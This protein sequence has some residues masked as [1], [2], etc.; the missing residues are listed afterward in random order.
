[1]IDKK[2]KNEILNG[3]KDKDE[4][5]IISNILDKAIK[6]EKVDS[7]YVSNFLNLNELYNVSQILDYFNIKYSIFTPYMDIEKKNIAFIPSYLEDDKEKVFLEHISCI[8]ISLNSRVRL[9][10]K[11]YMGAIYSLGV[12][13]EFVGDIIVKEN[14]AYFFCMK[15]VEEYFMYNL[16][17]VGK[18]EV[19]LD[20]V[21]ILSD[22]IKSLS[23]NF[24]E[25]EY[26]VPSLRIDAILSGVY[27]LSRSETK[28]KIVKGDLFINDKNIFYPNTLVKKDDIISF[29]KCGKLRIGEV[30]RNTKSG[31]L[32]INIYKYN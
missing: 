26:I 4:K 20:R 7:V 6:F 17:S 5:I 29:K 25:K 3:I 24:I 12:K 13:R 21:D 8:K 23:L 15:S 32:V 10:H 27:N 14:I 28:D 22:E 18:Y 11:D 16:N 31:N 9:L 30:L 19:T 1:M 2:R